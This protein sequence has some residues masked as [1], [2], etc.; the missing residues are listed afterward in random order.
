MAMVPVV[1][2]DTMTLKQ[3]TVEVWRGF[4]ERQLTISTLFTLFLHVLVVSQFKHLKII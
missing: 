1:A 3:I 4:A 2:M